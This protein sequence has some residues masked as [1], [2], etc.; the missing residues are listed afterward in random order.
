MYYGLHCRQCPINMFL[1][2]P[3]YPNVVFSIKENNVMKTTPS[4]LPSPDHDSRITYELITSCFGGIPEGRFLIPSQEIITV[5]KT[6]I[7]V[8]NKTD[9]QSTETASYEVS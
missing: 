4:L 3:D 7:D 9:Q 1:V 2:F 5:C 6:P 8:G